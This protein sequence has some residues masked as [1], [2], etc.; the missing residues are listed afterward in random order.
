MKENSKLRLELQLG[1]VLQDVEEGRT[2]M[3]Y[4]L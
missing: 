2:G 4:V 1:S 3:K